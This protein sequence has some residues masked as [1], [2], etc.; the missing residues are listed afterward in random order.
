MNA[1]KTLDCKGFLRGFYRIFCAII[2]C[3][4][5]IRQIRTF[6]HADTILFVVFFNWIIFRF[7]IHSTLFYCT[8]HKKCDAFLHALEHAEGFLQFVGG[9]DFLQAEEAL[10]VKPARRVYERQ[11]A[12]RRAPGPSFF[13]WGGEYSE[14]VNG[15]QDFR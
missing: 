6:I 7:L 1:T 4:P 11:R 8:S 9:L 10:V 3:V 2:P 13:L 14:G 15:Q 5:E 12:G